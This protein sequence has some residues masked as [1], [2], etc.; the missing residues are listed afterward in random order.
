MLLQIKPFNQIINRLGKLVF[1]N[2]NHFAEEA[3]DMLDCHVVGDRVGL[4]TIAN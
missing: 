2:A 3:K 1:F 4:G